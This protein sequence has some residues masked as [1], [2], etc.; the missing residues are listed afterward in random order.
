MSPKSVRVDLPSLKLELP[1]MQVPRSG[2][3][4]LTMENVMYGP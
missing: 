2:L 3:I 1:F 4:Y